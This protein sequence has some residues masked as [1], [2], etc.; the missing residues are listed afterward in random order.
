MSQ[1]RR[2]PRQ[3]VTEGW[4]EI[5]G[6]CYPLKDWSAEGFF[7]NDGGAALPAAEEGSCKLQIKNDFGAIE[8]SGRYRIVRRLDHSFA[9]NWMLDSKSAAHDLIISHFFSRE[10]LAE[11]KT[12]QH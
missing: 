9:G 5:A 7:A 11:G 1:K 6:V 12:P 4:I 3:E 10:L 8:I 2:T